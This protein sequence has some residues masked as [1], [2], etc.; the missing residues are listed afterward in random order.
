ML[1]LNPDYDILSVRLGYRDLH[2]SLAL[3]RDFLHKFRSFD[4][5][6]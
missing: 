2:F 4:P 6:D 3:L 5:M 1:Y